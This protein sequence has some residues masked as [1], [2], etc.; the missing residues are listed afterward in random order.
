MNTQ[1]ISLIERIDNVNTGEPWFGRAVYSIL[2]EVTEKKAHT[3]P[4]RSAHTMAEL[5]YHLNTWAGF[6]LQRIEKDR[7]Y[8]L[9]AAE[10]L[11][12]RNINPKVNT[13]KKG[14][15]EFKAIHKK[16]VARLKKSDDSFL[17]E[18]VEYRTYNFYFLI[19]GLIEHNIYHLGQIAYINKMLN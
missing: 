16:I 9:K 12:W 6:T 5:L 13:W 1:I 3:R 19:N 11:D 7:V 17:E 4:N 2:E 8:D 14:L 18:K 15:T 10:E